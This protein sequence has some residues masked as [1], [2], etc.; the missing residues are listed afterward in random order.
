M[1][2]TIEQVAKQTKL[3]VATIRVYSSRMN[4]GTKEGNRRLFSPADVKKLLKDT[5]KKT[6]AKRKVKKAVARRGASKVRVQEA[7]KQTVTNRPKEAK[8][9]SQPLKVEKRSFW[10]RLFGRPPQKKTVSLLSVR[11]MK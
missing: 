3:K 9:E 2:L 5:A 8:V 4:L 7:Q 11:P 10:S 1:K 6:T